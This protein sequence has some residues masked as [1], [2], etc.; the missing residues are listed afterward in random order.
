LSGLRVACAADV[1]CGTGRYMVHLMRQLGGHLHVYF[2][3]S[4]GAMLAELR[5]HLQALG[6]SGFDILHAKAEDMPLPDESLD[7]MLAFNAVHHF[8]LA[9]FLQEAS[10]TLR[11]SGLLFIYTRFRDQNERGIW[12]RHF[13]GF[14][15][16]E[17][18][19]YDA[20]Q[21]TEAIE[22]ADG[23]LV[24]EL[25]RLSF[26]RAASRDTLLE[27]AK[28]KHYSTFSLYEPGEL[29][30]AIDGFE[31][32]L[33]NTYGSCEVVEWRDENVMITVARA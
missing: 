4:S 6:V 13:P 30:R 9:G 3:D 25:T 11:P 5:T 2:I 21:V 31:I 28:N 1:G 18:R 24:R 29:E 16:K 26:R 12:G 14:A 17:T 8:D 33:K 15:Q 23:L 7:C 19:L 27:R 22:C 32:N 20:R 10:R